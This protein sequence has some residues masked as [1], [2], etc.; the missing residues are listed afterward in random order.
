M[1]MDTM[2]EL[3]GLRHRVA[4]LEREI[5]YKEDHLEQFRRDN[6]ALLGKVDALE[7]K[8]CHKII[9]ESCIGD[10]SANAD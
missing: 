8:L 10:R 4:M 5:R 6:I 3:Y 7:A 1:S 9:Q 2:D